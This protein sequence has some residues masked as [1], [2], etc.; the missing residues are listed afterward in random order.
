MS[1]FKFS[2]VTTYY[3]LLSTTNWWANKSVHQQLLVI[4]CPD[5]K[6]KNSIIFVGIGES[7]GIFNFFIHNPSRSLG[8]NP[9]VQIWFFSASAVIFQRLR[10]L[11]TCGPIGSY[12]Y[13]LNHHTIEL[14]SALFCWNLLCLNT[15]NY[16]AQRLL[17]FQKISS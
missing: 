3:W 10:A 5:F 14:V 13:A 6:S 9:V 11:F 15:F 17:T 8:L 16:C 7:R 4:Y 1:F 2:L 12:H